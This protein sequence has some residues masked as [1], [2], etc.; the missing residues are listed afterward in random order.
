M[1]NQGMKQ[2]R[3]K[4][5]KKFTNRMSSRLLFVFSVILI[6]MT[7]LIGRIVWLNHTDGVRYEKKV[8]SQQTYTSTT[9]PYQRGSILDRNGTVLAYSEKVYNV[10]LDVYYALSEK[11]YAQP[12]KKAL[13]DSFEG[14]TEEK[15][16][17]LYEEKKTSRYSVIIKSIS[18]EDME[19][20]KELAKADKNIQGVWFEEDYK[21][22]YPYETLASSVLGFTTSDNNGNWGIEQY[23]NDTLNG[24]NGIEFGY[25]DSELKL[26]KNVKPSINGNTVVSTIDANVQ[27]IVQDHIKAYIKEYEPDNMG[28]IV[29]NPNNG[30]ILAMASNQEYDL[31][32]P[33][34]LTPFFTKDEIKGMT[35]EEKMNFLNNLW[36]NYTISN[37][38]EPGSTFKPFTIAAALE[39]NMIKP[40]DTF[41]CDGGENILGTFVGC[42]KRTG[43]GEITLTQALM[44]SCNDALMQIVEKEGTKL[45][46]SYQKYFGF[47]GRTGIDLPGED[48]GILFANDKLSK[49][50]LAISSFGQT[51][52]VTMIQMAAGY[53]SLVNGGYY[54]EPHIVKEVLNSGG[55]V[56]ST[57]DKKLAKLSVSSTTSDFLKEALLKTV[58]EGTAH[59]AKVAGYEI[60]GKTGTAQTYPRA[61]EEKLLSFIGS[62][63][64]N[65]PQLVVYVVIHNPKKV[66]KAKQTSALATEEAGAILAEILPLLEIYPAANADGAATNT[67]KG[68]D[69]VS[70]ENTGNTENAENTENTE[71][72]SN[73]ENGQVSNTQDNETQSSTQDTEEGTE[74][75]YPVEGNIDPLPKSIGDN[76][77]E[78]TAGSGDTD[79]QDNNSE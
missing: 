29:M 26:E 7:V 20:F 43:H 65:D 37:S 11:E 23:Y 53:S 72:S 73:Q 10:I 62:V 70:K 38:I 22:R 2:R 66:E 68:T 74:N 30:E 4:K 49:L 32:K 59:G 55:S 8:L 18:Y 57:N 69:D 40:S 47:G 77:G 5:I 3:T 12:T 21:R 64:A 56:V 50:D 58:D 67:G 63:P 15:I 24:T 78:N 6:F 48:S 61:A 27:R 52:T 79:T 36:R 39:E 33:T 13:I 75:G 17:K 14:V 51:F 28:V 19:K 45:F 44:F 42:S 41:Y 31:N 76:T 54:Y 16:N 60:G 1:A 34:D 9:I 35:E 25:M 71:N 46:T